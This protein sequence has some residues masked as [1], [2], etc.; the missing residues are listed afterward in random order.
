MLPTEIVRTFGFEGLATT[1]HVTIARNYAA[2]Q[3]H[4]AAT[5][6]SAPIMSPLNAKKKLSLLKI[7]PLQISGGA[8]TK[9]TR[10]V[11]L[12]VAGRMTF[13]IYN[14]YF[15]SNI[16]NIVLNKSKGAGNHKNA[17]LTP[18]KARIDA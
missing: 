1:L 2:R 11:T 5:Q 9:P 7:T 6:L 16:L 17:L 18:H 15:D 8:C 12:F 13:V 14:S 3:I 4:S 10:S